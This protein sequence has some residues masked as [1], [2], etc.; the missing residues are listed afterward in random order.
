MRGSQEL[1]KACLEQNRT[2]NVII[3]MTVSDLHNSNYHYCAC[4]Q[5]TEL[6]F[7]W[8]V[9][10]QN[11]FLNKRK[12]NTW[13]RNGI[14]VWNYFKV[15]FFQP[16]HFHFHCLS[17]CAVVRSFI[18]FLT[19]R[20]KVF[21]ITKHHSLQQKYEYCQIIIITHKLL[22]LAYLWFKQEFAKQRI[23]RTLRCILI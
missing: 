14:P 16:I 23:N 13:H 17:C 22:N 7:L 1:N 4:M 18:F 3:E 11:L 20:N 10:L 9:V 12:A 8:K 19:L 2:Y 5:A 15:G 6:F 21:T